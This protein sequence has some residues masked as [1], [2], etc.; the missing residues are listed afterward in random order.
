ML[1]KS[2]FITSSGPVVLVG[3]CVSH[4]DPLGY[5]KALLRFVFPFSFLNMALEAKPLFKQFRK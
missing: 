3:L 4:T 5:A 1:R 2:V